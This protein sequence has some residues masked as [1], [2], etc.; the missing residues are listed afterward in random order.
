MN[1]T[2]NRPG[3]AYRIE[4]ARLV[5]RCWEPADA[6]LL[7]AAIRAS[8]D[9]LLPWMPWAED[10]PQ[11]LAARLALIRRWRGMFD[12]DQDYV[13]GV[14]NPDESAVLGGCGLHTRA[15]KSALEIGYWIHADYTGRG[16]ATE[17]AAALTRAAFE[18][19]SV[20]RVEI[21]MEPRNHA[22][23]AI[24][25]KLGYRHIA[26][27]PDWTPLPNG[28]WHSHMLWALVRAD[29]PTSPAAQAETRAYDAAGERIL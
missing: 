22:S 9:H 14:F 11:P 15:G 28:G 19:Q 24:P 2:E 27:L 16:L 26:T 17:L 18:V 23:A 7:D 4:T 25:K 5:L 12:L 3:P 20:A 13:Y 10:E 8:V 21:H 6:P 1:V 29:Y